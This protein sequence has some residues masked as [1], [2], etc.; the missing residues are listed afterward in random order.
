M[1]VIS[2]LE[3]ADAWIAAGGPR[4]RAAEWVGIAVGESG[5]NTDAVSPVGALGLWQI[6]PFNWAPNGVNI[7]DWRDPV[8]NATVAVRMSGHGTNCA[9]W[10]SCYVNI[11]ASGRLS[12]L[13]FPQPG[14][15]DYHNAMVAAAILGHDK[16]GGM[17]SPEPATGFTSSPQVTQHID[18]VLS[19]F[20]PKLARQV[21]IERMAVN[22]SFKTGWRP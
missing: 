1:P 16:L 9:A 10:D 17:V 19:Q 14:S 21:V 15:A 3:C 5:L 4:N 2:Y 8:A 22:A 6:M 20:M 11:L 12:Y 13:A 7:N 18:Y